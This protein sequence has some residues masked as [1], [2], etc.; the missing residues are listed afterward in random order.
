[1]PRMPAENSDEP[2]FRVRRRVRFTLRSLFGVT[3]LAAVMSAI[4]S[5]IYRNW[6]WF[7]SLTVLFVVIVLPPALSALVLM[8][9][10]PFLLID[11]RSLR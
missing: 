2:Q 9:A 3:T 4:A 11:E 8:V 1:M 7:D 6:Q 10:L 5:L